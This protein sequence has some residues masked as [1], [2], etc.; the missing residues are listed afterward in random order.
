MEASLV[1]A[2]ILVDQSTFQSDNLILKHIYR[3][4]VDNPAAFFIVGIEPILSH[5]L[6]CVYIDIFP[7]AYRYTI[8]HNNI[9][10]QIY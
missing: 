7:Y 3:K 6:L 2:Q 4:L 10:Y 1:L 8:L 5:L 9:L